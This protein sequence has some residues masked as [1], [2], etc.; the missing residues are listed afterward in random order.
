MIKVNNL[1]LDF[2]HF[3]DNTCHI[4]CQYDVRK[5]SPQLIEWYYEDDA[6]VFKIYACTKHLQNLGYE[7]ALYLPYI[8]N[9]RMD[10]TKSEIE[11]F[12]LKWFADL[13]NSLN[14]T[15]VA[16]LDPHS[17]VSPALFDRVVIAEPANHI[18]RAITKS[19]PDVIFFPDEGAM[20]RYSGLV[21]TGTYGQAFGMKR[22]DWSTGRILGLDI[23]GDIDMVKGAKVLII[24]DIC[25]K[26]GTFFYS[27]KALK[28]AGAANIDLYITHCEN[29]IFEGELLKP[30][31]LIDKIYTT[32]SIYKGEHE[33]IEVFE[34]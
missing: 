30:D 22:R 2:F 13:I 20:K 7:V 8:P 23:H 16:V 9:A 1:A 3:P 27:A 29:T 14:F 34:V 15:S 10:R 32:N 18:A 11:V 33:K 19:N 28:E 17:N 26:G 25:S 4:N 21:D 12:T 24:D 6:E 5:T 31:S